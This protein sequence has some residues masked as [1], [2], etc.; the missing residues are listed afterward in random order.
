MFYLGFTDGKLFERYLD[1]PSA[2]ERA[3]QLENQYPHRCV[4]VEDEAGN[5]LYESIK[6]EA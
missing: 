5:K 1:Y 6:P 2:L 4:Q 3:S